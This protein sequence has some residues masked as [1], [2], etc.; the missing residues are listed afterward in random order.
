MRYTRVKVTRDQHTV[1]NKAVLPW[2]IPILEF[3]FEEGNVRVQ[4]GEFET[5]DLPYPD[6]HS[7]FQRLQLAYGSDPQSGTPYVSTVYGQATAGVNHLRR[8]IVEAKQGA[9]AVAAGARRAS[10][11]RISREEVSADPLMA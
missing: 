4:D 1:Y 5:N 3:M 2:E 6:A 8:V 10:K 7:E 9:D 11:R